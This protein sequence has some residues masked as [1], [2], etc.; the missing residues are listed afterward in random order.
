MKILVLCKRHP[1]GRDLAERPYGRF[2]YLAANLQSMG[3]EVR[4]ALFDHRHSTAWAGR[5]HGLEWVTFEPLRHPFSVMRNLHSLVRDFRPDWIF[6]FSDTYYG[7]LAVHLARRYGARS[8]VD[9]YDNYASYIEW[10]RPLHNAWFRAAAEADLVTVAGP[11]LAELFRNKGRSGPIMLLPMAADPVG[12]HLR[13][14]FR[15]RATF[16]LATLAP[17]IGYF[18]SIARS[19]GIS[20]LFDAWQRLRAEAPEVRLLLGGRLDA[21][22]QIPAGADYLGYLPDS[23]VPTAIACSDVVAVVNKAS[24][25]GDYSYPV[26][27]YEA[28][29]LGI[30]TVAS[31]TASTRWILRNHPQMLV[32]PENV[33]ALA[34]SLKGALTGNFLTLPPTPDWTC[35]AREL[36]AELE[37]MSAQLR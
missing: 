12:F 7:V 9:A 3:H 4:M 35:L 17:Y 18:G 28:M 6:G 21:G 8:M 33:D 14:R 16:G 29:A 25:F 30:P 20:T 24:S 37:L 22:V 11:S 26:K 31:A 2:Y 13:D 1:M 15:A 5:R 36:A 27:L 19:R 10:C 34:I 23:L 32:E